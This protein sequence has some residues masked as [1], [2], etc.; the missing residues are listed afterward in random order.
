MILPV[1]NFI[2]AMLCKQITIFNQAESFQQFTRCSI[3][4]GKER[5]GLRYS[6]GQELNPLRL[7]LLRLK[8]CCE[9]AEETNYSLDY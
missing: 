5:L 4:C 9:T 6:I 2:F 1:F 3:T 8:T 7:L